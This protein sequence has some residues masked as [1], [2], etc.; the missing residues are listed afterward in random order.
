MEAAPPPARTLRVLV[1]GWCA[2][3]A[4][5]PQ[6]EAE[7]RRRGL[8]A[9]VH[10][11]FPDDPD[12]VSRT[13]PDLTV[14]QTAHPLRLGPVLGG[15]ADRAPDEIDA[16]LRA[17]EAEIEHAVA[18]VARRAT[19]TLLVQGVARPVTSP[20]GV[21]DARHPVG[22]FE[23]AARLDRAAAAHGAL[24]VDEDALFA[25]HGKRRLLDDGV[26][27]YAHHGFRDPAAGY[28]LLAAAWLDLWAAGRDA[29]RCVVVDLDGTLWP[30]EIAADDFAFDAESTM[31]SMVYGRFGGLHEALRAL[32]SRG[33]LLVAVGRNTPEVVQARWRAG[34]LP[35]GCGVRPLAPED[36]AAV[37]IGWRPKREL[38][39]G[40]IADLGLDPATVA[41]L[42]D[43][44]AD[45]E[46]VR[47]AFPAA[48]I[49]DAE[50][51]GLR[52]TLLGS[53]RLQARERTADAA[54]RNETT[55][56]RLERDAAAAGDRA[57]F[58]RSLDVRCRVT[59]ER[60][61]SRAERIAELLRRTTQLDTTR[62]QPTPAEVAALV[63]GADVLTLDVADRFADYGLV[64]VAIVEGG[65]VTAFALSCRVVGLDVA[66]VLLRE[67][68][69]RGRQRAGHVR[70]AFAPTDRNE[71]ARQ[72]FPGRDPADW[73][74]A[75]A[76][77]LPACPEHV[78]VERGR[79]RARVVAGIRLMS[80]GGPQKQLSVRFVRDGRVIAT[81]ALP[82]AVAT[83]LRAEGEPVTVEWTATDGAAPRVVSSAPLP[84]LDAAD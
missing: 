31:L 41:Y 40:V 62:L 71:P 7:A 38:V 68:V 18:E 35:S 56:A 27:P 58:L 47:Q 67:A 55:R 30:G 52:E 28:A 14:I 63:A 5:R 9:E 70:V 37:R 46:D 2:V 34:A 15:F 16:T 51:P 8:A 80:L 22:F 21:L 12:A 23:A 44:P 78:R 73:R 45:R 26:A 74:V 84:R 54:R 32:R 60:D 76:D 81:V 82:D 24:F 10:V 50:D 75:A 66:A 13:A 25:A 19:G 33:V 20:L 83:A 6:L 77:P 72:L 64:G 48:W 1:L 43:H 79:R 42:D 36:F 11:A 17:A 57:A 61:A 49:L 4:A 65:T 53:P 3:Q 59:R 39:G 69:A 29:I